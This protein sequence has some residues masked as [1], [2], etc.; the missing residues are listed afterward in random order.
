MPVAPFKLGN[1]GEYGENNIVIYTIIVIIVYRKYTEKD[2]G[3]F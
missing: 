1:C 2:G 3:P